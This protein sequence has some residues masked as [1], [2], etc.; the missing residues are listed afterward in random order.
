MTWHY[1]PEL[2]E[3]SPSLPAPAADSSAPCSSDTGSSAPSRSIPTAE[4][5][6]SGASRTVCGP[7]SRSG[8][9]S[10]P[11]TDERFVATW[12]SSLGA[13]LA[14]IS[15]RPDRAPASEAPGPACGLT[16][17]AWFAKYDLVSC[18]WKT[19]TSL[20]LEASISSSEIWPAWGSMRSGACSAAPKSERPTA[21]DG[22][23]CLPTPTASM[24]RRGFGVSLTGRGRY[25]PRVQ[26]NVLRLIDEFGWRVS[27]DAQEW[28]MGWII[29]SSGLR[30]LD[31]D[32][33]R[34]WLRLHTGALR[35]LLAATLRHA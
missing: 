25:G 16:W 9:T 30:P 28:L 24:G 17:R 1:L 5:C 10:E 27:P 34:S 12:I 31:R 29:A 35:R 20:S 23:T 33:C 2:L 21:G 22:C 14:K 19:L 4:R 13:S 7:C 26:A 18:S 3:S 11:L 6:F 32:K 15:A 8:M